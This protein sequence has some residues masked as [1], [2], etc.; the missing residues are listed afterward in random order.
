VHFGAHCKQCKRAKLNQTLDVW[1]EAWRD[2][3]LSD[4]L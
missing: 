1:V 4:D 3:A 2:W